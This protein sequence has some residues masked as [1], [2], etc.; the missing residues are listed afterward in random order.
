MG[1]KYPIVHG[2]WDQAHPICSVP[3]GP[4]QPAPRVQSAM[5]VPLALPP[6]PP[7]GAEALLKCAMAGWAPYSAVHGGQGPWAVEMFLEVG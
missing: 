2:K 7:E 3:A 6:R 5:R 1:S 4:A